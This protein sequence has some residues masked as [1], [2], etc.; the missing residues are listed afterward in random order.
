MSQED[1]RRRFGDMLQSYTQEKEGEQDGFIAEVDISYPQ[2]LHHLHQSFPLA[3]HQFSPQ[4]SDLSKY[5]STCHKILHTKPNKIPKLSGTFLT[6]KKYVVHALNLKLYTQLGMKI[7]K[8]H[9]VLT[10]R[11]SNF[12]REYIDFCTEMRSRSTNKIQSRFWKLCANSVY[13]KTLEATFKYIDMLFVRDAAKARK[14]ISN[15]RFKNYIVINKNLVGIILSRSSQEIKQAVAIGFSILELSKE[16]MY[17]SYYLDIQPKLGSTCRILFSDTDSLFI[18]CRSK[19]DPFQKL[20]HILDTSNFDRDHPLRSLDRKS[21][22][23]YFKSEVGN[24]SILK[25]IG[26]RSKVYTFSTRNETSA[27]C[28][29]L[30]RNYQKSLKME[31]FEQCL[32]DIS[33]FSTVQRTLMSQKHRITLAKQR[34]LCFSSYDDK[35]YILDCG[36]HTRPFGSWEH[37][38]HKS[39]CGECGIDRL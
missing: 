16:F 36:I 26:L 37:L 14:L 32:N 6:R 9:R 22:V 35:F 28:K 4:E 13:G 24:K 15:P 34:K 30:S 23:G 8:V 3:P 25:F 27:K 18:S 5:Q 11:E 12:L 7:E 29:G 2:H 21:K 1:I 17:R 19:K 33:S 38:N 10:F 39:A 31:H 20:T